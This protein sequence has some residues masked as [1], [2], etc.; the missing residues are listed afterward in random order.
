M[1]TVFKGAFTEEYYLEDVQLRKHQE[2]VQLS[3]K[4]RSITTYA[5]KFSRLKRFAPKLVN[6]NYRTAWRFV[7]G[8][9]TKIRNT[10]EAIAPTT[11]AAKAMEGPNSSR[12]PPSLS[13]RQK[14]CHDDHNDSSFIVSETKATP[15]PDW[16]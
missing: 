13:L 12:E 2:F 15:Y 8:L 1:V 9:D 6:T 4:G 14:Q 3:Q 16:P 5:R 10:V 11:Y 7:L